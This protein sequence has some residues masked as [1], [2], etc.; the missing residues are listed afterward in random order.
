VTDQLEQ[1]PDLFLAFVVSKRIAD[2]SVR[3]PIAQPVS[4]TGHLN[5]LW[6]RPTL[7]LQPAKHGLFRV[8]API[9]A[10]LRKLPMSYAFAPKPEFG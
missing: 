8:F 7:F 6:C 9:N 3:H 2:E 5:V 4:G 1:K 10:A